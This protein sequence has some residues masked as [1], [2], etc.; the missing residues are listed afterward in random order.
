[1]SEEKGLIDDLTILVENCRIFAESFGQAYSK[2]DADA[3]AVKISNQRLSSLVLKRAGGGDSLLP[4]IITNFRDANT[5]EPVSFLECKKGK[6][7]TP[8]FWPNNA[9]IALEYGIP[10]QKD[11]NYIVDAFVLSNYWNDKI[12]SLLTKPPEIETFGF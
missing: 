11:N 5:G 9:R 6:V 7:A 2:L 12:S 10:M 4:H 1:M 3:H 8:K